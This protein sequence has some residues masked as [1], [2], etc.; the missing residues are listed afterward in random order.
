L[1]AKLKLIGLVCVAVVE[2]LEEEW[3]ELMMR[4][5]HGDKGCGALLIPLPLGSPRL[6]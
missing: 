2:S 5:K 3:M 6:E 1:V 4:E